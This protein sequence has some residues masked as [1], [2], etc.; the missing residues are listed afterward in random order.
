MPPTAQHHTRSVSRQ[1]IV[2]VTPRNV[3]QPVYYVT[4]TH[5]EQMIARGTAIRITGLRRIRE[6]SR[7]AIRG[8]AREWRPTMCYDPD[9]RVS[10]KTMQLVPVRG[11]QTITRQPKTRTNSKRKPANRVTY[12]M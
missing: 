9:T 5:A 11:S 2:T 12:Q 10:I 6:V 3:S 8:E 4:E 1:N 7:L